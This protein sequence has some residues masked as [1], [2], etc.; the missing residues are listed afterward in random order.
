MQHESAH[1]QRVKHFADLVMNAD[2]VQVLV[3]E[4]IIAKTN[5]GV[6]RFYSI[7][8]AMR[9]RLLRGVVFSERTIPIPSNGVRRYGTNMVPFRSARFFKNR[10]VI[11][12]IEIDSNVVSKGVGGVVKVFDDEGNAMRGRFVDASFEKALVDCWRNGK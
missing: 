5:T 8:S 2:K 7:D 11:L 12:E 9:T 10:D 1:R 3:D 4:D 6:W